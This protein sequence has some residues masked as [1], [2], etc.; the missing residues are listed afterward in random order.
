[1]KLFSEAPFVLTDGAI[2]TR[3]VHEFGR[4]LGD[5]ETFS[6]LAD[7]DGRG[8]LREIYHS[9]AAVAS[10]HAVPMQLG[11][12]TWHASRRYTSEVERV[13]RDAVALVRDAI[14]PCGIEH[15]LAGVMGPAGDGYDP[16][17]ALNVSDAHAYHREQA[18]AL[19]GAGVDMIFAQTFPS[20]AELQGVARACGETKAP[21]VLAPML[22][23]DGA[24][25]DGTSLAEAIARID[26][27]GPARPWHYQLICI[28]AEHAYTALA[29][30]F[31]GAP[32]LA[33]RVVGIKANPSALPPALLDVASRVERVEPEPFARA[34]LD[35]AT[36]FGLHVVGGCCGTDARDIEAIASL[37]G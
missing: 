32:E 20:I 27:D 23:D 26:D 1:M 7:E 31:R 34:V 29:T 2:E 22:R 24:M 5:A 25:M 3:V 13:N 8:I 12:P 4:A 21:F 14:A 30:L 15:V 17:D 35:V 18:H 19:V 9:Y 10:K 37:R 33:H 6:L 11:T 36:M 16:H 28:A